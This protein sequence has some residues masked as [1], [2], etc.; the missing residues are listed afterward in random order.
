MIKIT[1]DQAPGEKK[2]KNEERSPKVNYKEPCHGGKFNNPFNTAIISLLL[3]FTQIVL[4][5]Q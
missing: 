3:K 5:F 2:E 1:L 4:T